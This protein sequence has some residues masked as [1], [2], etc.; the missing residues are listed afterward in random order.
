[1]PKVKR[2]CNLTISSFFHSFQPP[3][4]AKAFLKPGYSYVD[5]V[6]KDEPASHEHIEQE[7]LSVP[8]RALP[9]VLYEVLRRR[10]EAAAQ[11]RII[12]FFPTARMAQ[13]AAALF[14]QGEEG[15]E[16]IEVFGLSFCVRWR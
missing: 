5:T 16:G 7:Y 10:R 13:F 6:G 9:S 11:Y 14:R 2:G 12:V 4:V 3:R 8:T 1:M 15:F